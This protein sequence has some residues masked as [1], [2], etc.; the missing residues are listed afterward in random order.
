MKLRDFFCLPRKNRRAPN[1]TRS[2]ANSIDGRPATQLAVLPHS[3]PDLRIGSS[4]L[5]HSQPDLGTELL[6][7][8]TSVPSPSQNQ[9]L[10]GTCATVLRGVHLTILPCDPDNAAQDPIQEVIGTGQEKQSEPPEHAIE[11]SAMDENGSNWKSTAYATT[12]LVINLLKESADAF[13]PLKSAVGGLSVILDHRDVRFIFHTTHP[14]CSRLSQRTIDCR[15]TIELLMPRVE[16]LAES[17]YT[18]VPEGEEGRRK[19]LER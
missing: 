18:P 4:I 3:Q 15:K 7:P 10:G 1:K 12:K 11:S 2:E 8:S 14:R 17:L 16:G 9:T 13:P 6:I 5:P 19:V